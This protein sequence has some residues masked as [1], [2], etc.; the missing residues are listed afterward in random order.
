MSWS[1]LVS[2]K[3]DTCLWGQNG[4]YNVA[5]AHCPDCHYSKCANTNYTPRT[6]EQNKADEDIK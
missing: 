5:C 3:C 1:V 6:D 2:N 4:H